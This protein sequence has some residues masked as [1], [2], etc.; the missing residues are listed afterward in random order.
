MMPDFAVYLGAIEQELRRVLAIPAGG[1]APLYQMMQYHMGWLD[2]RFQ[3]LQARQGK[4]LRP[5]MCLLA[6]EAVGGEWERAL[7]AAVGL[8]LLHNFSLIHDDIEDDS[9]TRRDRR[10]VWSLWGLA[11]GINTGDAMWALSRLAVLRLQDRGHSPATVLRAVTLLEET[12]LALC[13]GQHLDL[14]F[15]GR[16][17]VRLAEYERMIAGKTAALISA[18]MALGALLGGADEATENSFAQCGHE[19][20]LTFQIIDDILGIWGKPQVTGKSAASDN[21]ERKKTRPVL[22]ALEW[23]AGHELGDLQALYSRPA[24]TE[25]EVP[26]VLQ[27]LDRA[28]ARQFARQK[29]EEHH[30]LT[31]SHLRAMRTIHP[32]QEKLRAL[33]DA[34]L[35]RSY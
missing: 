12:S 32:A 27:L 13:S 35:D 22:Y 34:L 30:S 23:E 17:R 14:S 2:R 25:A 11:Q 19:L 33:T 28:G 6:C 20:G 10:T 4:H 5:L 21:R 8:E 9:D 16:P 26:L 7:P 1:P 29:A 3:P 18:S 24:L 31:R 15:E